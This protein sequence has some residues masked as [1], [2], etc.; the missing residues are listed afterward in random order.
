MGNTL[1]PP[2][3]AVPLPQIVEHAVEFCRNRDDDL[4]SAAVA[5]AAAVAAKERTSHQ[6][7]VAFIIFINMARE[8]EKRTRAERS[9]RRTVVRRKWLVV[10]NFAKQRRE[11]CETSPRLL[12]YGLCTYSG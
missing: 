7:S 10:G 1:F 2:F 3:M 11:I 6:V 9:G 5:P 8:E 12:L 4:A